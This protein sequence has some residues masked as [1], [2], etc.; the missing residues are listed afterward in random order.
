MVFLEYLV[1]L[2]FA[3]EF[4]QLWQAGFAPSAG[5]LHLNLANLA[6]TL[7]VQGQLKPSGHFLN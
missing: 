6:R 5:S 1:F 3:N 2:A 4:A 7:G